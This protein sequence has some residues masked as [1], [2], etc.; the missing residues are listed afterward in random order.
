MG[1]PRQGSLVGSL[2]GTSGDAAEAEVQAAPRAAS[3]ARDPHLFR[4]KT[5]FGELSLFF[6]TDWKLAFL[7]LEAFF[8]ELKFQNT[9]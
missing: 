2:E 5:F 3:Q 7:E 1:T 6:R 4:T 8:L 9:T